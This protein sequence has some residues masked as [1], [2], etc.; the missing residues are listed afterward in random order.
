MRVC[1]LRHLLSIYCITSKSSIILFHFILGGQNQQSRGEIL[2]C[3]FRMQNTYIFM[4]II[5]LGFN[6]FFHRKT[7]VLLNL[8]LSIF[9]NTVDPD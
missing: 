5:L 7:L 8:K 4:I 2:F 9:E 3:E 1:I 6:V